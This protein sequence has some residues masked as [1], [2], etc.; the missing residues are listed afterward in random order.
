MLEAIRRKELRRQGSKRTDWQIVDSLLQLGYLHGN[1]NPP[2]GLIAW[3]A[4][5]AAAYAKNDPA[6]RLRG[7][8]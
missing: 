4:R 3:Q 1:R 8:A 7:E 6:F 2:T 5:L